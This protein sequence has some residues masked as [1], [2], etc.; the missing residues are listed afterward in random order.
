MTKNRSVVYLI[1]SHCTWVQMKIKLKQKE[2]AISLRKRGNSLRE[3]SQK[4][5]V[6][7]SSVSVWCRN[8][9]LT[10]AQINDLTKRRPDV[11]YGAI[12]NKLKRER[13][14]SSIKRLAK[15]EVKRINVDNLTRLRDIGTAIY[16][17]EG[18]KKGN[19]IDFTNSD[20]KMVTL[21][22]A[23]FRTVCKVCNDKFRVSIFY[24]SG[25]NEKEMREYWSG[26]TGVP[27]EQF[28][29]SIFKKEGTGHRK[30]V[31]YNGTCKVRVCDSDLFHRVIGW[32]E[33]FHIDVGL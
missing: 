22:M 27:L 14:I 8:V 21:M 17:A 24:H 28:Y 33:Q 20:P 13:E 30:N 18:T 23:W 9:W 6:S 7:K 1:C 16:W 4:L 11:N 3:I 2:Q 29:K 10:Q 26:V 15:K 5:G 31:L 32:I 12:A 19:Y 25:Q